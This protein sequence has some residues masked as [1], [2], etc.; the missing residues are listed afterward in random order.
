MEERKME[1]TKIKETPKETPKELLIERNCL[2]YLFIEGYVLNFKKIVDN[3]PKTVGLVAFDLLHVS[4]DDNG[5]VY[6]TPFRIVARA[7][8]AEY[9]ITAG[10]KDGDLVHVEGKIRLSKYGYKIIA[11]VINKKAK[12]EIKLTEDIINQ[13][14]KKLKKDY[15]NSIL[16]EPSEPSERPEDFREPD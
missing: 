4:L 16:P 1:E 6:V 8:Q 12:I 3:T 11:S 2:Q 13:A 7:K 15:K 9:C 10:I 5:N 14:L